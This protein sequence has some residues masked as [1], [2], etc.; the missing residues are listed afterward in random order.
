MASRTL[1]VVAKAMPC[2]LPHAAALEFEAELEEEELFEDEAAM[3]GRGKA[4]QLGEGRAFGRKVDFAQRGF[5][6]GKIEPREHRLRQALGHGAAHGFEQV[7]DDLALPARGQAAAAERF[8]DGRDAADFKQARFGVV[9]CVGQNLELRLDH[10]EVAGGARGLDLAVDRDGL[11][12]VELAV[13]IGGVEPDALHG[14]AALAEGELEERRPL[15]VRSRAAPRTSAM[16]LA[17]SPGFSSS[18]LR[19]FWRSS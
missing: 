5:A 15:R 2:A 11:A 18:R 9:G 6:V 3:G 12:G 1:S 8:V 17:I 19:G 10:F 7:E 4:L 16:T 13:E 14:A